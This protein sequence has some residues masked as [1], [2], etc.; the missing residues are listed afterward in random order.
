M[1]ST[2][3]VVDVAVAA[4]DLDRVG[5][6]LLGHLGGEQLGH[7]GFLE[8]GPSGVAQRGGVMHHLSRDL[9]LRRHVGKAEIHRLVFEDR[10]AETLAFMGVVQRRLEGRAG[11]AHGLGRNADAAAFEV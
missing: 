8:A 2:G 11:H 6:D 5:A 10:L 7:R 9:D 3:K 1:R 4:V